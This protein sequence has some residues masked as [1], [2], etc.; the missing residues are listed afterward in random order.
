MWHR[1]KGWEETTPV[2]AAVERNTRS[3]APERRDLLRRKRLTIFQSL[4]TFCYRIALPILWKVHN[5]S[6][7]HYWTGV[8]KVM[9][10]PGKASCGPTSHVSS[11]L[12]IIYSGIQMMHV[13]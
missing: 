10:S 12:P 8:R 13:I 1:V 5:A 6:F 7:K 9:N 3:A 4:R 2:R 11:G